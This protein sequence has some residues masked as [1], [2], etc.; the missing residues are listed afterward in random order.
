MP[1]HHDDGAPEHV[2][3]P[4]RQVL[5]ST[6]GASSAFAP[7]SIHNLQSLVGNRA[8]GSLLRDIRRRPDNDPK[9]ATATAPTSEPGK[10][11]GSELDE[12][13]WS[14]AEALRGKVVATFTFEDPHSTRNVYPNLPGRA[15]LV[16]NDLVARPGSEENPSRV[17]ATEGEA[18]AFASMNRAA[19]S[20]AVL[21][22]KTRFVV[23]RLA[24]PSQS[25]T[26]RS[27]VYVMETKLGATAVIGNDGF[28]FTSR[29]YTPESDKAGKIN[30]AEN[31]LAV[32]VDAADLRAIVGMREG[33][34]AP[35]GKTG[36][37]TAVPKGQERAFIES[38]LRAR[39]IEVLTQNRNMATKLAT[40]FKPGAG[41]KLS[42][43]STKLISQG[44]AMGALYETI[45]SQER[46]LGG[47]AADVSD[48]HRS[49][50]NPY[51]VFTIG[52]RKMKY[53][54][55]VDEIN[56]NLETI[57]QG[58]QSALSMSPLLASMVNHKPT[59]RNF[60]GA[61]GEAAFQR[62]ALTKGI[63]LLAAGSPGI[64][65]AE[66][67]QK[68]AQMS[69]D[70]NDSELSKTSSV[71]SDNKVAD[72]FRAKLDDIQKALSLTFG[73]VASE[74]V[75]FLLEM[76]GLRSRVDGDIKRLG[77]ENAA[78]QQEWGSLCSEHAVK[79]AMWEAGKMAV[80]IGALFLPGGQFLS[81]ALGMGFQMKAMSDHGDQWDAARAAV[82]PASALV[83]QQEIVS[84]LL[85]DAVNLAVSAIDMTVNLG[86]GLDA[87]E[88]GRA[89]KDPVGPGDASDAT[90][91]KVSD[92]HLDPKAPG[93]VEVPGEPSRLGISDE[94]AAKLETV[95]VHSGQPYGAKRAA[96]I[97]E[98]CSK[99]W[100]KVKSVILHGGHNEADELAKKYL[101]L[102]MI[103]H[104]QQQTESLLKNVIAQVEKDGLG[105]HTFEAV[106]STS[107]A[108]DLD[109]SINGPHGGEVLK[110]FNQQ[111]RE[112]HGIESGLAFDT[113]LYTRSAHLD[114]SLV[115]LEGVGP[116]RMD[117]VAQKEWKTF[118]KDALASVS[119][120]QRG[121]LRAVLKEAESEFGIDLRSRIRHVDNYRQQSVA[122]VR[123][124]ESAMGSG[125]GGAT[126]WKQYCENQLSAVSGARREVLLRE[127][128]SAELRSLAGEAEVLEEM[129]TLAPGRG[130]LTNE[131][132]RKMAH[133]T[134][135]AEADLYMQARNNLYGKKSVALD[136]LKLQYEAATTE[137]EKLRLAG[138]I[139][140]RQSQA[141]YF[142]SEA[143][144]TGGSILGVVQNTQK[145]KGSLSSAHYGQMVSAQ[146]R[147]GCNEHLGIALHYG[148]GWPEVTKAGKV[149]ERADG[150]LVAHPLS[151]GS[152]AMPS[153]LRGA[154]MDLNA[155]KD[156]QVSSPQVSQWASRHYPNA[157]S[158]EQALV[159]HRQRLSLAEDS[160]SK[161]MA[162]LTEKTLKTISWEAA[163]VDPARLEKALKALQILSQGGVR[164]ND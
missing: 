42:E 13:A 148:A 21:A 85:F 93:R 69:P 37:G 36:M 60:A 43:S 126:T 141:L 82:D 16:L 156:V 111:F 62:S 54:E 26:V 17:F 86:S 34:K 12:A 114:Y 55:Y 100:E 152:R 125:G 47:L 24:P 38:Y 105:A 149:I 117:A 23:A 135:P 122:H 129:K 128:K 163:E 71:E 33:G 64:L 10:S 130:N 25:E 70:W 91:K 59:P 99:N 7:R 79:D 81:A 102:Q 80:Q 44:R 5:D 45:E 49:S 51:G 96:S 19:G 159:T 120:G 22:L 160:I 20:V 58:K 142:A 136:E 139:N 87:L 66:K 78:V 73:R 146:C 46:K 151:S 101:M 27:N 106:G 131:D 158:V 72:E 107:L 6:V 84:T 53:F 144:H 133:S 104:R 140:E 92:Q 74:D 56:A 97:H 57:Y 138:E 61:S 31:E 119:E 88:K 123:A 124:Y 147:A 68:S 108:S 127:L 15:D 109:Y 103:E 75:G 162:A 63:K 11:A 118:S 137:A 145:A 2:R 116:V 83:D 3:R 76:G 41:G 164:G 32:P 65:I 1:N 77:A 35:D 28:V 110:R 52:A 98:S 154:L 153:D 14:A 113:N 155:I 157:G 40:D 121:D 67:I 132:L 29:T 39:A 48:K 90:N 9:P 134:N 115:P 95:G 50:T 30:R 143:N 94:Y 112:L 18:R 4:A 89:L 161:Q 8:T 150:F